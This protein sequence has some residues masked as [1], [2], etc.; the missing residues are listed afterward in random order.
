MPQKRSYE[1]RR[2]SSCSAG[3]DGKYELTRA[4]VTARRCVRICV[5]EC[6]ASPHHQQL[7][8]SPLLIF[9]HDWVVL[10]QTGNNSLICFSSA[11]K[12]SYQR[13]IPT[14]LHPYMPRCLDA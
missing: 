6:I 12:S 11:T 8:R 1:G 13:R 10:G 9:A 14:C 3:D 7:C 5:L 4:G 2:K